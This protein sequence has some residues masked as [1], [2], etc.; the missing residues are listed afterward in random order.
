MLTG[1]FT[2]QDPQRVYTDYVPCLKVGHELSV[3]RH[4]VPKDV[5]VGD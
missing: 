1:K 5:Q 2:N 4:Y 3:L